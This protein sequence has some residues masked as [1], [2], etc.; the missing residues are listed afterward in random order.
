M[1]IQAEKQQDISGILKK[2]A[3]ELDVPPSKYQEAKERYEAVGVWL[4][5]D[6]ELVPY[7]PT[8][9]PQGSFALGTAVKPLNDDEYDVDAVCQ[10]QLSKKD[11]TQQRLKAMIGNR[12]KSHKTYARMLDPWEGGRR[13]WTLKYA[14]ESKFHLDILPAVPDSYQWL[15]T[16]GVPEPR[17]KHAICITDKETWNID[18][19]WPKS[20]PKGYIE[21]FKDRMRVILEE[22]RKIA[23]FEIRADVQD[24]P[25][26]EVRT[27]LQT[28]IQLFKRHRDIMYNGDD[29]KPISII[30]TTLAAQAYNNEGELSEAIQNML[31]K[32]RRFI[33]IRN[34]IYWIPNPVNPQE[35]FADKWAEAPQKKKIFFDW[36][37]T[38]ETLHQNLTRGSSLEKIG[39]L[40]TEAYGK[41][42][43]SAALEKYASQKENHAEKA[44]AFHPVFMASHNI[45]SFFDVSYKEPLK[46]PLQKKY[47]VSVSGKYKYEQ[48]W[49]SFTN[50]GQALPKGCDLFFYAETNALQPFSVYWQVVNTGEEARTRKQLRGKIFPSKTAGIGGLRQKESTAYRGKHWI[51]CFIVQNDKCVARSG[52]FIVNIQ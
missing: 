16:L 31:P 52:E 40:L 47:T 17:A 30:I 3:E 33:E 22:R 27:P 43:A 35:N 23:A 45:P 21:W 36:L 8:I 11:I 39:Q 29:D 42:D 38:I 2:M 14:D 48:Q 49:H 44:K 5:D 51:E 24:V 4:N 25:D 9:Y 37:N 1:I 12:L 41:R 50:D 20:N 32:M 28:A 15:I 19:S 26:Y 7:N 18:P 10:L 6:P 34:G 13:C 46:W